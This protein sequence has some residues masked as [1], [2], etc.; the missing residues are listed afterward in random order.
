MG[1]RYRCLAR[2]A[3]RWS[4]EALDR[5]LDSC[6]KRMSR[7]RRAEFVRRTMLATYTSC[8]QPKRETLP[9]EPIGSGEMLDGI[10]LRRTSIWAPL[11]SSDAS[12]SDGSGFCKGPLL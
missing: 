10:L 1:I 3:E 4:R 7:S 9:H 2:A 5:A 11:A 12:S 8:V 6:S